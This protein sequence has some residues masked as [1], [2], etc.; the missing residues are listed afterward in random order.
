M[1]KPSLDDFLQRS[2]IQLSDPQKASVQDIL[3]KLEVS[4]TK[5]SIV[6]KNV[7]GS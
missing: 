7:I 1:Q 5:A 6:L 4:I 3:D 2:N